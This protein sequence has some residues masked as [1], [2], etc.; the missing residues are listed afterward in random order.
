MKA[1]LLIDIQNDFLP[2]GALPVPEGD[3]IIPVVNRLLNYFEVV[4]ATQDWHP[5]DHKSFASNH[6]GKHPYEVIDINGAQQM[7]WPDHCVQGTPGAG[8]PSSLNTK[9]VQTI[10]RKGTHIDIDSYSGFY[11]NDRRSSTGLAGYLREKK[12]EEVYLVGLA[13]D[14][15]VFATA[16]DSL[17]EGFKTYIIEDATRSLN[18]K[19]FNLFMQE[20][21]A[22]GGMVIQS[23]EEEK[24]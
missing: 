17:E 12:V 2:A 21:T 4:A 7:L 9:P 18:A 20:F 8:F 10:F 14:V 5:A 3:A 13:G 22:K 15:C 11:D 24:V 23:N 19:D 1:L 6:P 16:M